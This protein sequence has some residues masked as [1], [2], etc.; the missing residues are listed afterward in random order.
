MPFKP[1]QSGNPQGAK[2]HKKTRPFKEKYIQLLVSNPDLLE[3][4]CRS[5]IDAA[6]KGDTVAAKDIIDRVEGKAPQSIDVTDNRQLDGASRLEALLLGA[7]ASNSSDTKP[8]R[9]Q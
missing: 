9:T 6:I 3:K 2:A 7:V 4:F 5:Q 8:G 1:G